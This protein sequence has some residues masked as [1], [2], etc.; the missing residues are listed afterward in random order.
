MKITQ[1]KQPAVSIV[2]PVYK[3]ESFLPRCIDS[4][5]KQSFPDWEL[6]LVDD[7]SPDASGALCEEYASR[8]ERICVL[9]EENRGQSAARNTGMGRCRGEYLTFLDADDFLA[10]DAL[11]FLVTRIKEG[12][13]DIVMAGHWRVEPDG[14]TPVQSDTWQESEDIRQIQ[15]NILCNRLPNFVWGK[16]YRRT[17]WDGLVFP[18]GQIME[19]M[20]I[21]PSVFLRAESACVTRR[22]V[23][24]YSHENGESTMNGADIRDY[25]RLRYGKFLAWREH[26]KAAAR[27]SAHC[28]AFCAGQALHG[29][30]RAW[31]LAMGT[32]ILSEKEKEEIRNYLEQHRKLPIKRGNALARW[33][34]L[35]NRRM[36]LNVAGRI[37]RQLAEYQQARRKKRQKP[38][39]HRKETL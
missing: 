29:A 19:D 16:L 13:F 26:E 4:V 5:L 30:V 1:M 6:I 38:I 31:I 34:I 32:G 35:S 33:L 14:S 36:L 24:F 3:A 27:L 25:I 23:Y 7:G 39:M 12:S 28:E 8:D 21:L 22:P 10:A 17:L 18:E 15:E 11:E 2:V 9:H 20:Y 37:Q